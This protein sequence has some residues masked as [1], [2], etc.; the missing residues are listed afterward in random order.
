MASRG[1]RLGLA[2]FFS[3]QV[4]LTSSCAIFFPHRPDSEA[5]FEGAASGPVHVLEFVDKTERGTGRMVAMSF[6]SVLR[7]ARKDTVGDP[8]LAV[9]G[10]RLKLDWLQAMAQ[11]R[12]IRYYLAG[13]IS[14]VRVLESQHR[15][16]LSLTVRM[17]DA[18]N[19]KIILT[20]RL[21]AQEPIREGMSQSD[22]LER[23]ALSAAREFVNASIS[24]S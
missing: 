10:Q 22:M 21:V 2:V 18:R 15:L 8:P 17:I 19:G 4:L 6:L 11:Q 5:A 16:W 13:T 7:T 20:K 12:G 23:A 9:P 1:L 24:S 14:G 3:L